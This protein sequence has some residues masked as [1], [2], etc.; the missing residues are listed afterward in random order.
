[1]FVLPAD[2]KRPATGDRP[3]SARQ[4]EFVHRLVLER[5]LET[6]SMRLLTSVS[7][8]VRGHIGPIDVE[9]RLQQRNQ[10]VPCAAARVRRRLSR[11]FN[12]ACVEREFV[13]ACG[14]VG[15]IS[16]LYAT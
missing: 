11:V 6:Q 9:P 5:R 14:L 8:R 12:E 10:E 13:L 15:G 7:Q 3:V 16:I 2:A 4:I 1:M